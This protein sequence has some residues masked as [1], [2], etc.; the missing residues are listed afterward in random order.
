MDISMKNRQHQ[1]SKERDMQM[2]VKMEEM[3]NFRDIPM[4]FKAN[5]IRK[6]QVAEGSMF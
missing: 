2:E 5:K 6:P 4:K 3:K 1:A